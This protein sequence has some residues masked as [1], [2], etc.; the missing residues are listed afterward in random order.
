LFFS[1]RH[2][3]QLLL[4]SIVDHLDRKLRDHDAVMQIQHLVFWW[5][6]RIGC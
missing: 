3:F 6:Q 2:A 4:S 1:E 5:H